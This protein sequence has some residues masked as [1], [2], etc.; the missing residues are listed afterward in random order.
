[1]KLSEWEKKLPIAAGEVVSFFA[2][3]PLRRFFLAV[4]T[5]R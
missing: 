3:S 1:M 5:I 2:V 4:V